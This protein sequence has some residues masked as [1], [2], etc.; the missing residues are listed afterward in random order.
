MKRSFTVR[1]EDQL[2]ELVE[3]LLVLSGDRRIFVLEGEMGAGKTTLIKAFCR[4]LDVSDPVSS[5]SFSIVNEYGRPSG[6]KV[7][8]IDLY[9][10]GAE[11]ELY[12]MGFEEILDGSHYSFIEWPQRARNFLPPDPVWIEIEI[13]D[14]NERRILIRT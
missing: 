11:E 3:E 9:R 6:E 8:H 4:V 5:P 1:S 7:Y 14:E 13:R 10:I 2:P 12:D